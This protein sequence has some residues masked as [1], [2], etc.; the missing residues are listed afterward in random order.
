MSHGNS[1][2]KR[3]S[4]PNGYVPTRIE[5]VDDFRRDVLTERSATNREP[6]VRGVDRVEK[7]RGKADD[8]AQPFRPLNRPPIAVVC[9]VDD[10]PGSGEWIRIRT[11]ST[12]IGRDEGEIVIPHDSLISGRHAVIERRL[13]G[14]GWCWS[15]R[16]LGSRNGTL[17]RITERR[18]L[19]PG[20]E[21]AVGGGRYRFD[22]KREALP[23]EES[24]GNQF[25]NGAM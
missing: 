4:P 8:D 24:M 12:V 3:P 2:R 16:D 19:T 22:V 23:R 15:V 1:N 5:S 13:E 11:E 17:V 14:P 7:L 6:D 21:I 20:M 25:P 18:Q 9:L 10:G